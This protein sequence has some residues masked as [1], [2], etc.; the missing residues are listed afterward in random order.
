MS[1]GCGGNDCAGLGELPAVSSYVVTGSVIAW[2]GY[3]RDTIGGSRWSDIVEGKVKQ[4]LWNSGGFSWV[5]AGQIGGLLNQYVSIKVTTRVDF[6]KLED[7]LRTIEGAIYQAGFKPETQAF[8]VES[9]PSS[10]T[11]RTDIATPGTGGS[12]NPGDTTRNNPNGNLPGTGFD[13][14][15]LLNLPYVCYSPAPN[16]PGEKGFLDE[17]ADWLG[18]GQTEAAVFGA[19]AVVAGI[20]IVKKLL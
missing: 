2:G 6:A 16:P 4:S 13:L 20:V 5:D 7:V 9:I 18:I 19:V 3:V 11:G 14:C 8:W 10:A 17:L 1:C 12:V 15:K